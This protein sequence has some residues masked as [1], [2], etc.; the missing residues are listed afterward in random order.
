[1]GRAVDSL[2]KVFRLRDCSQKQ[3]FRFAEQLSLFELDDRP[4]CLRLEIGTCL[5]PCVAACGREAYETQ[6]RSAAQFLDGSDHSPVDTVRAQMNWAAENRQYE[7][8]GHARDTL[9]SLEYVGRKLALFAKARRD[10]SFIYPV[11]GFD[12]CTTWY[13]ICAGEVTDVAAAGGTARAATAAAPILKRWAAKLERARS[14]RYGETPHTVA[15]VASW[16]RKHPREVETTFL[17]KTRR[18][19]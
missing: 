5:G 16:F 17:P 8:A 7:L 3:V 1:M 14:R 11:K 10:Y 18:A 13:L 15:M 19:K 4:G 12:G 2:N 9:K 6:V